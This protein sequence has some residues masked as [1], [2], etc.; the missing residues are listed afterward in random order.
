MPDLIAIGTSM[1]GLEALREVCGRLPPDLPAAVFVVRHVTPGAPPLLAKLLGRA[2]P[3]PA[4]NATDGEPVRPGRIYVA[5][6]DRHLLVRGGPPADRIVRLTRGPRENHTRPA[7]DPLFRSLA[8]AGGPRAV[9]VVLTGLLNDGASGL[10]AIKRCGGVAVVQDPD[11]AA[12]PDMPRAALQATDVDHRL[13]L[14]GIAEALVRIAHEPAGPAVPVPP[15]LRAEVEVAEGLMSDDTTG[16][17]SGPPA[18]FSC[19][20]CNGTLWQVETGGV[21]RFRCRVGHGYTA[22]A[23]L[24]SQG[25]EIEGSL[26][27]AV[28]TLRERAELLGRLADDTRGRSSDLY[29]ERA[30]ESAGHSEAIRQLLVRTADTAAQFPTAG[31]LPPEGAGGPIPP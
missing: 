24:A 21:T 8:V 14:A 16:Y 25:G 18:R 9:G 22:E 26:W 7:V 23:L 3:L 30:A 10:R 2:G 13:T 17:R 31:E 29:R 5:P 1:G 15:E 4:V 20:D 11:E 28:R 12:Y 6:P 19:P 27:A